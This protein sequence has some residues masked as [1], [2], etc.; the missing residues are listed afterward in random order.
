MTIRVYMIGS[1]LA[2]ILEGVRWFMFGGT[3][4]AGGYENG[5]SFNYFD[6]QRIEVNAK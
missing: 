2:E 3:Y 6:V 1:Q 5:Q 4:L